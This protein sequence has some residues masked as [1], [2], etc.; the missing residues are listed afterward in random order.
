M[1]QLRQRRDKA[2]R[3]LRRRQ[4]IREKLRGFIKYAKN[5]GLKGLARQT[6]KVEHRLTDRIKELHA[7][8]RKLNAQIERRQAQREDDRKKFVEWCLSK[9]GVKEYSTEHRA[10]AAE[11]GYSANLPWCSIFAGYGL[12]YPGGFGEGNLPPNPAYSGNWLGWSH[13][14]RVS[15][16]NVQPGDL[17]IFDWGDGGLTDH[18]AIYTGN[19][20]KVGGNENNQVEH[21]SVP[22]A[23]IVGVVRPDWE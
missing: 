1:S 22:T 5:H 8:I 13:G 20:L 7:E 6:Q 23:N 12:A 3:K 4:A 17:L 10:W 9:V 21:D 16:S 2:E 18:V 19:G 15:Y 11:L 14:T